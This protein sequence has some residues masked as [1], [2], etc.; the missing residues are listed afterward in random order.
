MKKKNQGGKMR[1]LSIEQYIN[2]WEN[3]HR[4]CSND[5]E[6]VLFPNK[7]VWFNRFFDRV[8]KYA[9]SRYLKN[10]HI[11]GKRILDLGCG[12]GRWLEYFSYR[13]G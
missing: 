5:L 11:S 4:K 3:T 1:K 7:P 13:G 2:Y 6:A 8:Q 10:V 12:R 9:I